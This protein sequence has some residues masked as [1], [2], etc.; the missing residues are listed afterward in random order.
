VAQGHLHHRVLIFTDSSTIHHKFI[1]NSSPPVFIRTRFLMRM[2]GG[3]TAKAKLIR[4]YN[5]VLFN[6]G[7]IT[8]RKW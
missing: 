6:C 3:G 2:D 8:C 1:R 4:L 5:D 7:V